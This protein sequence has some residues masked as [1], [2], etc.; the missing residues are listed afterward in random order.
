MSGVEG[1]FGKGWWRA[2]GSKWS[3]LQKK[4]TDEME[5]KD[6][7]EWPWGGGRSTRAVVTR[8]DW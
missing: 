8:F 2:R 1:G 5:V 3:M 4:R 7:E 6:K